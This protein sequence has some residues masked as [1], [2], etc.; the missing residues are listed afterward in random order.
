[1]GNFTLP[2][3]RHAGA[4]TGVEGDA[5]LVSRARENGMLNGI[6][7]A[8]FHVANLAEDPAAELW[9]DSRYSKV[10]LDPPRSGAAAVMDVL[11]TIQPHRI[12]YVSCHPGSLARD[13]ATLVH[14]KGYR[15][16]SAGVMDMFPHTSHV[17]SIALFEAG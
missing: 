14:E 3:A 7:N 4:V 5:R 16:L 12:V 17:E 10:L 11:G 6:D 2:I 8:T 15:L 9:A 13:A 1:L